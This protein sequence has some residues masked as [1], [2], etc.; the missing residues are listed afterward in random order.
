MTTMAAAPAG[1][2]ETSAAAVQNVW[3]FVV[4]GGWMMVPIGL[5]SVVALTVF[6]ERM[7]SLRRSRIIPPGLNKKVANALDESG[8]RRAALKAC[9]ADGSPAATVLAA[10]VKRLGAPAAVV[11]KHIEDEGARVALRL[12][13][14]LRVL[15]VVAAIAPLMGLLGTIFGMIRAFQTVAT[16]AD[17]LGKTELLAEGIYE[18]MITTAGGLIVAIPVLIGYHIIS[19]RIERLV[20]EIDALA[21]EFL[22]R[23]AD[24]YHTDLQAPTT[25]GAA[26]LTEAAAADERPVEVAP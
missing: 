5:C 23:H 13:K 7:I 1:E 4:K 12:R 14:H 15:Q 11:E 8:D 16:S 24:L 22:D 6:A 2:M 21:V 20:M 3:D 10:G 18:A 25:N 26:T 19:A 9:K 17:A